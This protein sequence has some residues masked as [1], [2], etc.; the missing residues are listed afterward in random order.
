MSANWLYHEKQVA[1]LCGVHCLNTLLQGPYFSEL[2]LAQIGQELDRLESELLLGG[3][4]AAGEAGN[5][6]G[7]GMFSIQVLS[8][9]L[10]VW[11]LSASPITSPDMAGVSQ[12]PQRERAFI[13]NLQEHWFTI[14]RVGQDWFDFNS[15]FPAPQAL[16]TFYLAAFLASLRD[17]GFTI[18][19]VRGNLPTPQPPQGGGSQGPGH[20]FSID[21]AK[22][23]NAD[24]A[25]ARQRGK[26]LNT[27]D[28]LF[29]K[30]AQQGGSLTLRSK[31]PLP[32]SNGHDS[33]DVVEGM[34]G[35]PGGEDFEDA[36]LA[37]A[38]AAS[39][40]GHQGA[41]A[42]GPGSQGVGDQG[43]SSGSGE[44]PSSSHHVRG[45]PGAGGGVVSR[46]TTTDPASTLYSY[47]A[48][49]HQLAAAR[50][51]VATQFPRKVIAC[52]PGAG[53]FAEVGL[54]EKQ[55]LSVELKRD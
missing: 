26:V 16:G 45:Q 33:S 11:S 34:A 4:K 54:G 2:D 44:G 50:Y 12:E 20:W 19:V 42:R 5:V 55:L 22:A 53:S 9:A 39:L 41:A 38:I 7:S 46:F 6:D 40:Q 48:A 49:H 10:Q 37:A 15:T 52:D 21:Q 36:E 35:F 43:A 30:A 1:A 23:L 14:R 24:A 51:T 29:S 8:R 27:L 28:G 31:R 47:L 18:Y 32:A 13:C 25:A 3:A 17:Q